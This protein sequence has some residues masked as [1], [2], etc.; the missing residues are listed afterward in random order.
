M[1]HAHVVQVYSMYLSNERAKALLDQAAAQTS[2]GMNRQNGH[3]LVLICS[4]VLLLA[5][6]IECG[7]TKAGEQICEPRT[8]WAVSCAAVLPST[9]LRARVR[10]TLAWRM[11]IGSAFVC[12][13][14]G[15]APALAGGCSAEIY[16]AM[17]GRTA[18]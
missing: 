2:A 11:Q 8:A 9:I 6:A 14:E 18:V 16:R 3:I 5:S 15:T 12:N 10:A 7:R 1:L 13:L 4:G 17:G